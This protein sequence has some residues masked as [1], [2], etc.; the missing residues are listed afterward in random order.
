MCNICREILGT[1]LTNCG[2]FLMLEKRERKRREVS[3]GKKREKNEERREERKAKG[4]KKWNRKRRRVKT[5]GWTEIR[6]VLEVQVFTG[7]F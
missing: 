2:S 6:S 1:T 7:L 3:E 4:E 5:G